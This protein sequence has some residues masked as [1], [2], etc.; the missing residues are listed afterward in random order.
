MSAVHDLTTFGGLLADLRERRGLSVTTIAD[1]MGVFDSLIRRLEDGR[2]LPVA[3]TVH[4]A[5]RALALDADDTG[6]LYVAAGLLPPGTWVYC[7]GWVI[8]PASD[9]PGKEETT[10]AI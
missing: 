1:R 6:R 5:C 10:N 9:M 7:D 8:R 3:S 4:A 2:R